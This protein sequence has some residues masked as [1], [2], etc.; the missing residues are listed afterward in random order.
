[1]L[2]SCLHACLSACLLACLLACM[3]VCLYVC[4]AH[5]DACLHVCLAH[6]DA[7]LYVC[8][9]A[10]TSRFFLHGRR[11]ARELPPFFLWVL[12][13]IKMHRYSYSRYTVHACVIKHVFV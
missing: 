13:I 2:A 8:P 6:D 1:M 10:A 9:L 4:L 3:H 11:R 5:D 12:P 7:C